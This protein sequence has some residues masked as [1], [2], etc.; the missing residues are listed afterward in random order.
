MS[1]VVHDYYQKFDIIIPELRKFIFGQYVPSFFKTDNLFSTIPNL[2]W[3]IKE[4]T[5]EI[6]NIYTERLIYFIRDQIDKLK[7]LG[8]I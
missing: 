2:K 8:G 6:Q 1:S 3:E 7:I 5:H 4:M